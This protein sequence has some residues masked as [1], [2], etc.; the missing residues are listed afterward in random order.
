MFRNTYINFKKTKTIQNFPKN[1]FCIWSLLER[2]IYINVGREDSLLQNTSD[3]I[4]KNEKSAL[5][6]EKT[7]PKQLSN[8]KISIFA[9]FR[10]FTTIKNLVNN[11]INPPISINERLVHLTHNQNNRSTQGSTE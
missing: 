1:I 9:W 7:H 11:V 10:K 6:Q 2:K 4:K 5:V 8:L 3:R